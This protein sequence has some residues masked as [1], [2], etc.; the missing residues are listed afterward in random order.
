MACSLFVCLF[1]FFHNPCRLSGHAPSLVFYIYYFI[2]NSP[3]SSTKIH[4]CLLLV[5]K[6]WMEFGEG[7]CDTMS[8]GVCR[9]SAPLQNQ[10]DECCKH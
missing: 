8:K 5:S 10:V 4:L 1:V 2:R 6:C 3:F 9:G 7:F